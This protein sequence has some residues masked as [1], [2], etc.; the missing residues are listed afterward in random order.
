MFQNPLAAHRNAGVPLS[1]KTWSD[2]EIVDEDLAGILF[3]DCT[4]EGVRM[5][6]VNLRQTSFIESRFENCVFEDCDIQETLWTSCAGQGFR[7]AGGSAPQFLLSDC[8]FA[9]MQ[10]AQSGKQVTLAESR[11]DDL[12]FEGP[13]RRQNSITV[14][15]CSF[16]R[17]AAENAE[18]KGG[19]LVGVDFKSCSLDGARF[20]R[21]SFIRSTGEEKDFSTVQFESC[22]LYQ[23]VLPKGKFAF[24]ER[25]IFAECD[26]T[27]AEFSDAALTGALFAK[28][29][30]PGSCFERAVLDG[31]MFPKAVLTNASF[32]GAAARQSVWLEADLAGA[33]LQRLNAW[34]ATFRNADLNA[35]DVMNASFEEADLH[36]VEESLDGADLHGARRTEGW[37]AEREAAMRPND[38]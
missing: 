35:A 16:S 31:A 26:L 37:R 23:S 1:G 17:I 19:T 12:E 13:G 24:A 38:D 8:K 20:E 28:A 6:R 25:C 11:I 7:I 22:N 9:G 30:A 2:R 3:H 33:N 36:G 29:E 18:W 5:R 14:S 34:R 27:E 15:G 4:F 10:L 32:E 21:C